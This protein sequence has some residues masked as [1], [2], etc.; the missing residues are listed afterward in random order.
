ML[1]SP[2]GDLPP[3]KGWTIE[4]KWDGVRVIADVTPRAAHL[5]ARN[6]IDKSS[7]FP[8]VAKALVALAEEK[9][10]LTLDGELV[11]VDRAGKALRFQALQG[12]HLKG[13]AASHT[14]FVAFDVLAADG[15]SL[16]RAPWT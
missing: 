6:G 14:A 9:G 7:Q 13:A 4:P 16:T 15:A 3:L 8:M 2:A 5:W 12:R 10:S 1:A 11:A